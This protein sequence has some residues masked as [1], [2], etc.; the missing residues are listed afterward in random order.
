MLFLSRLKELRKENKYT[1]KET[2]KYLKCDVKT[3][4]DYEKGICEIPLQSINLLADL[5][6]VS[7][8]YILELTDNSKP[9]N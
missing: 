2:A 1:K 3:Y 8:D 6:N 9:Y 4:S 5:Y 7:M